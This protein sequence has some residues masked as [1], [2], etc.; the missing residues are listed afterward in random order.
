VTDTDTITAPWGTP[1]LAREAPRSGLGGPQAT[2][3][4]TVGWA[5]AGHRPGP[6]TARTAPVPKEGPTTRPPPTVNVRADPLDVDVSQPT[7]TV[8]VTTIGAQNG[9]AVF[10]AN[11]CDATT[12][13]GCAKTGK[14]IGDPIGPEAGVVDPTNDSLYTANY[15][16][17]L[18]AFDLRHRE[19]GDLTGC[20]TQTPGTVIVAPPAEAFFEVAFSLVVDAPLHMVYVVNQ[21]DDTVSAVNGDVCYSSHL[22]ACATLLPPTIHTGEDAESIALDPHTQTLYTANQDTNDVSIID[23]SR[24]NAT[25]MSGWRKA[26]LDVPLSGPG[27]LAADSAV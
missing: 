13:Q 22:S 26:P 14:L 16:Y 25:N 1:P 19:A 24:C 12:Q 6:R 5:R 11:T 21:R 27:A 23:A 3:S 2:T 20:A 8:Y 17:T 18:S 4:Q 7:H 15:D 9:W 10:N